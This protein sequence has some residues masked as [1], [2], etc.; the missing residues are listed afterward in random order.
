MLRH[1]KMYG[2]LHIIVVVTDLAVKELPLQSPYF[3]GIRK[4]FGE[5]KSLVTPGCSFG[6][7]NLPTESCA[8]PMRCGCFLCA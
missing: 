4:T 2:I 8:D 3:A 7:I 1:F 6:L 5:L